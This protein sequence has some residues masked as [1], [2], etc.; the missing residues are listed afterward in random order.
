MIVFVNSKQQEAH[1]GA[2]VATLLQ[3]LGLPE[4]HVAV[5]VN[6]ELVT[7]NDWARCTLKDGDRVEVV[8]FVGGG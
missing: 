5:E 2:T 6:G 3:Q 1:A 4:K 7:R 8:S